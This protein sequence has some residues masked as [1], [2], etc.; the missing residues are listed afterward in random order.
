MDLE[1]KYRLLIATRCPQ[2]SGRLEIF[3]QIRNGLLYLI[4]LYES[5]LPSTMANRT[6]RAYT[7]PWPSVESLNTAPP[8]RKRHSA[9]ALSNLPTAAS[10]SPTHPPARTS[11]DNICKPESS[12]PSTPSDVVAAVCEEP[13]RKGS[14]DAPSIKS[15]T[16]S[17]GLSMRTGPVEEVAPWELYPVPALPLTKDFKASNL[18]NHKST[19]TAHTSP[20]LVPH[21]MTTGPVEEVTPWELLPGPFQQLA[22]PVSPKQLSAPPVSPPGRPLPNMEHESIPVY[23]RSTATGP[24]EDVTP[25]ELTP[26]PTEGEDSQIP[27][28]VSPSRTITSLSLT[29]AQLEEVTPWELY[30]APR[31]SG[32]IL[33]SQTQIPIGTVS[34]KVCLV[35]CIPGQEWLSHSWGWYIFGRQPHSYKFPP[36]TPLTY[37]N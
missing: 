4:R 12:R 35:L 25:W 37:K 20:S 15:R 6:A 34:L 1:Y 23:P 11:T 21:K 29:M 30:P 8:L 13:P 28:H 2:S 32:S 3:L 36:F 5:F 18:K 16:S 24:T 22:S 26:A 27:A 31:P 10:D 17:M 9:H 19:S 7:S 14:A 33:S